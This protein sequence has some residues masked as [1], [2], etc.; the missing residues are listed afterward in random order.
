MMFFISEEIATCMGN[1][2]SCRREIRTYKSA[3]VRTT[4][5]Q[6]TR[7]QTHY[8]RADALSESEGED[9]RAWF[10]TRIAP[11]AAATRRRVHSTWPGVDPEAT[12]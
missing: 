10:W 7:L 1:C 6:G 4:V 5:Q 3:R 11:G 2:P 8:A 12:A 9:K